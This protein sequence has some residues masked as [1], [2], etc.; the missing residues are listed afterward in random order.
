M[1][2]KEIETLSGMTRANIRFYEAEGLL[3]PERASNGYRDYSEE[4]LQVL[5]RIR[6]LRTLHLSLEEIRA[7]HQGEENL[8]PVLDRHIERLEADKQQ[9]D[10]SQRVCREMCTDGAEYRT[11]NAQ[12]YLDS[13]QRS[14][15]ETEEV[16]AEDVIPPVRAPWRRFLARSLDSMLYATL[17]NVFL[18]LVCNVNVGQRGPG[19][20]LLDAIVVP[21]M[22]LF[23]EPLLLHLFGTTLGKGI[24]GLYVTDANERRLSYS[25]AL[26][27]TWK[28]LWYGLGLHIPVYSLIRQ[29]KSFK[30]CAL[31][32]QLQWEQDSLLTQRKPRLWRAPVWLGVCAAL[33][34]G[35]VAAMM[36]AEGPRYRGDITVEEFCANYNR[37]AAYHDVHE[38]AR[39]DETGKWVE[40]PNTPG[41]YTIYIGGEIKKPDFVLEQKEGKVSAVHFSFETQDPEVWP[42]SFR[43]QMLLSAMS[44]AGAQKD[45]GVF[46]K[47]WKE[48]AEGIEAHPYEDFAFSIGAVDVRCEVEY[49]GYQDFGMDQGFLWPEDGKEVA[50]SLRFDMIKRD[51]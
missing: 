25:D 29:F 35:L 47:E 17:W 3:T 46:S 26:A 12:R 27:R 28:V 10:R 45:C 41:V 6:L 51:A 43:E 37:L 48:L 42:P 13:L 22:M 19:G 30:A 9:I 24:L 38:G 11:L 18:L 33:F 21:G 50:F 39:L 1:T 36:A 49:S 4:D 20:N 23:V 32:E 31:G 16:L 8:V 44:F 2:I 7:L 14:E 5:K 34:A 40:R 15:E